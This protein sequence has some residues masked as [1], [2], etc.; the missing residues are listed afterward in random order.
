[1][2]K[3]LNK[4]THTIHI[5][6]MNIPFDRMSSRVRRFLVSGL[7]CILSPPNPVHI[8]QSCVCWD[9]VLCGVSIRWYRWSTKTHSFKTTAALGV[10][11]KRLL[12]LIILP[13][14]HLL[15]WVCSPASLQLHSPQ[16]CTVDLWMAG[17]IL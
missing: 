14:M 9:I 4:A 12:S 8:T 5:H 10:A 6:N 7:Q 3:L 15:I 13:F 16:T 11:S 1:M 17:S 2:E